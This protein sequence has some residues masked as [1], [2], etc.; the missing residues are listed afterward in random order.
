VRTQGSQTGSQGL[1]IAGSHG[2]QDTGSQGLHWNAPYAPAGMYTCCVR[3]VVAVGNSEPMRHQLVV[4]PPL[5]VQPIH[6]E[7]TKATAQNNANF[8][9]EKSPNN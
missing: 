8:F 5:E 3:A 1:H 9:M 2:A 7:A 6:T 4:L